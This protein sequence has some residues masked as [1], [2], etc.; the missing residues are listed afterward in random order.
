LC[1]I[2]EL[3]INCSFFGQWRRG[4]SVTGWPEAT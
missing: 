2:L 1:S 4:C 3:L